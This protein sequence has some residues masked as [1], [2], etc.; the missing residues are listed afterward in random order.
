MENETSVQLVERGVFVAEFAAS[1]G[2][3]CWLQSMRRRYEPDWTWLTVMGGVVLSAAPAQILARV[4]PGTWRD[5]ERRIVVGFC[6]SAG[7][8]IPWQLWQMAKRIGEEQATRQQI[9]EVH[10]DGT[11]PLEPPARGT[12][13]GRGGSRGLRSWTFSRN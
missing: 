10:A 3:A 1:V 7:A 2:Y 4:L 6:V 9:G 12:A 8:I 13:G 11:K 5:Y